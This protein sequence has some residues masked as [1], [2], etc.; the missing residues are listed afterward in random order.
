MNRPCFYITI[1]LLLG[2]FG[3]NKENIETD[4]C[5]TDPTSCGCS[6]AP[7]NCDGSSGALSGIVYV[8][9]SGNDSNDGSENKPFKTIQKAA[10]EAD[11]SKALEI[12][13]R[14]GTHESKEIKFRTSNIYLHSYPGEWAVIKASTTVEDITSCLWFR[15]PT[16]EN[17]TIEN[18]E[19]VGGYLYGVKFE[20]NWED[21]RS[22]PFTKRRGVRNVKILNCKIH[23]TGRDCIKIAPG[24]QYIQVLNCEIYRSGIGPANISAQNAEGIDNV[25]GS[26]MTVRN[27]Y[28][29]DIA[30][31]GLYAKGGAKDCVFEQNLLMN[32]GE[33]GLIAGY[34]D[35]DAEWFDTDSNPNYY[36]SINIII[37]NNIV[38]N[39]KWEGVGLYAAQNAQVYNN[40]FINVAQNASAALLIARGEIYGTPKGDRFP[41]SK[42][43]KVANNIFVQAASAQGHMARLRGLPEGA[44]ELGYNIYYKP[45]QVSYRIDKNDDE[46]EEFVG[47]DNWKNK[48]KF[49][50]N[51]F[52]TNPKLD[53]SYHL[54][55]GSPCIGVGKILQ[56]LV[57]K[58]Y[59]GK[60]RGAKIDI[61]ADQ[62]NN[63]SSLSVPPVA[64][65]NG[66]RGTGG[67]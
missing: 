52:L 60:A 6:Q 37:R 66:T 19:I 54:A 26:N 3:C 40:T 24:C 53:N 35:T 23:D 63:G 11:T 28:I 30:T 57:E 41:K 7:P 55:D 47:F 31:N 36:E 21:D 16:T 49:D 50:S 39:T 29:H 15:E 25:N 13:L 65:P 58:D 62:Y 51:S 1:F 64:V 12:V 61:G 32:C 17:I 27:C 59:D 5:D 43:I 38:V 10:D 8:S 2:I 42:D 9:P 14:G 22:I 18:L 48:S 56:S 4:E 34:L 67:E 20:S 33:G 44:N 45:S 46:Y